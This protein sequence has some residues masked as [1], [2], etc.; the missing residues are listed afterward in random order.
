M[1]IL[2]SWRKNIEVKNDISDDDRDLIMSL[3]PAY[4]KQR[5]EW[6]KEGLEEGL[7]TGRQEGLQEGLRLIVES[8]LTARFGNLDQELSAV[9]TPIIELSVAERTDLLL[10]LYQLSREQLLTRLN[11]G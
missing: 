4:L 10:N 6:R 7:Q 11:L 8:L 9:V 5:E 2:A 3:S 1:E